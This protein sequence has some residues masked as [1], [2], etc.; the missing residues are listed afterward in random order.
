MANIQ[1]YNEFTPDAAEEAA[2]EIARSGGVLKLEVGKTYVRI[3]PP[4]KDLKKPWVVVHEHYIKLP[5]GKFASFVCPK[6]A[7]KKECP[8]CD[9]ADELSSTGNPADNDKAWDLRPKMRAYMNIIDK[10]RPEKGPMTLAVGKLVIDQLLKIYKDQDEWPP[11]AENGNFSHPVTGFAVI[12]QRQGTGIKDTKYDVKAYKEAGP[13][14]DVDDIDDVLE[15]APE[16]IKRAFVKSL[17]Q[18][19]KELNP[20]GTDDDDEPKDVNPTP[21]LRSKNRSIQDDVD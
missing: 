16:L 18:I 15:S 11:G 4:Q 2:A 12:I 1:K 9:K 6:M 8:A 14:C 20:N 5:A 21:A 3:L 7:L 19:R 13:M 17:E 10:K